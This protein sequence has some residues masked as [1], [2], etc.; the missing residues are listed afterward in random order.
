VIKKHRER[1]GHSPRWA[2]VPDKI[3]IITEVNQLFKDEAIKMK[4]DNKSMFIHHK[5][6]R[7]SSESCIIFHL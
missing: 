3:I 6:E 5:G 4:M 2:A 7:I 1:G